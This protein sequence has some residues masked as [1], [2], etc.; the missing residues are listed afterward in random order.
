MD[1]EQDALGRYSIMESDYRIITEK[2]KRLASMEPKIMIRRILRK[3]CK[4]DILV[5]KYKWRYLTLIK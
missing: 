2:L 5:L 4:A 3:D 1:K